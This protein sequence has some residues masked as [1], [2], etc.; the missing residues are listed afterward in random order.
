MAHFAELDENNV[1]LRVIVVSNKDTSDADGVEDE[2]IG[3]AFCRRLFGGK[4]IQ[5]SY[6]ANFRKNYAG[7]GYTYDSALD[8]FIAPKPDDGETWVLDTQKAQWVHPLA[9]PEDGKNYKW[10]ETTQSWDEVTSVQV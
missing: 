7:I 5:T 1:V 6:N 2:S 9:M 10:N 3:I 8:A 4:W